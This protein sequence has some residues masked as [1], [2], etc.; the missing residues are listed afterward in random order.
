MLDRLAVDSV[1]ITRIESGG[2]YQKFQEQIFSIVR[3][4][5]SQ[6]QVTDNHI[7]KAPLFSMLVGTVQPQR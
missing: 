4:E 1:S 6:L 2:G 7:H 3:V 5:V